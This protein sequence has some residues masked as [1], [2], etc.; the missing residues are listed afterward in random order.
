MYLCIYIK[1][2]IKGLIFRLKFKKKYLV[3]IHQ[4]WPTN[5]VS[6]APSR[7]RNKNNEFKFEML[8]QMTKLDQSM[9]LL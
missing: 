6:K 7:T 3:R 5:L 8:S 2:H 4:L 9:V 1:E